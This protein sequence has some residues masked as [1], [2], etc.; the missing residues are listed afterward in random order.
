[1]RIKPR[2]MKEKGKYSPMQGED[3]RSNLTVLDTAQRIVIKVG[4]ALLYDSDT[5]HANHSWMQGLAEDIAALRTRGKQVVLVSS[6]S[7]ALGRTILNLPAGK[8]ALEEKQAAAAAGQV[9]LVQAWSDVLAAHDLQS[10]QILLAPDDTETRRRH[11]NARATITTLLGLGVIPVVNENDTV[12]TYEIRYGDNDRLA[13]RVAGMISADLLILLSDVDGLYTA[14]PRRDPHA[15][16]IADIPQITPDILAMGGGTDTAFASGGM[17]TKLAAAQLATQAGVGM[18]ICDGRTHQPLAALGNGARFSLFHPSMNPMAA[19][20]NWIAG[21]LDPKGV[22]MIDA[23]AEKAL[24]AGKSLLPAGV[25]SVSGQFERGDVISVIGADGT[26]IARGLT[27]YS[28]QDAHR[29][30]GQKSTHFQEL[31][32]YDG[33]AELIHADDLVRLD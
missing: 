18:I 30:K 6:G 21:T 4:S 20:Q 15:R 14:S 28:D 17:A 33:R 2:L 32:G 23:G 19:R 10:A 7:I 3:K 12:T 25:V 9:A 1:M 13:A 11:L 27:H 5:H 22:V 26:E 31:V 8:I 24:K 29:L 16:H